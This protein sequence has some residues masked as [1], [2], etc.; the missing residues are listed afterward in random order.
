MGETRNYRWLTTPAMVTRE[1]RDELVGCWREV[2]NAG[3]AVG[4][5]FLPVSDDQ[6]LAALEAVVESLDPQINRLLLVSV[7]SE[8]AG[9]LLLS[10]NSS[11][12]TAHWARVL[13]VQTA[14]AH[15]GTGIGR[16]LMEEAAR[17]A[18]E[19]V[20]LEQLH[21]ELRSGLGLEAFYQA[22]GWREIGRWPE[23]L[24]F[25]RDD[26]DEVLMILPLT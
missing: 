17:S 9:W 24:R 14:L 8:V 5:P 6:V 20:G 2:A 3:G 1:L 16:M 19:D 25:H 15:R 21:L 10:G 12:L 7:G 4:F 26:R 11:P 13:R 23:A 22:L 18:R